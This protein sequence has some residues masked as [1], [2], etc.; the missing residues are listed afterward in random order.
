MSARHCQIP[1][2]DTAVSLSS[3]MPTN[4]FLAGEQ[5]AA[6]VP[7]SQFTEA[8]KDLYYTLQRID[9]TAQRKQKKNMFG[10]ALYSTSER[11]GKHAPECR[12]TGLTELAWDLFSFDPCMPSPILLSQ[13]I[14]LALLVTALPAVHYTLTAQSLYTQPPVTSKRGLTSVS[15]S[16]SSR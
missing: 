6:N 11:K 13:A 16:M 2:P 8:W 9:C 4:K 7:P 15:R 10:W 5:N 3:R 1:L 14:I 12:T